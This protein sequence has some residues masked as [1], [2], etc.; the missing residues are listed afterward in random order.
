MTMRT[1][2]GDGEQLQF[3]KNIQ[4][5]LQDGSFVAS[6]KFALLHSLADLAVIH[7]DDTSAPLVLTTRQIAEQFIKL[8]WQQVRPFRGIILKQNPGKQASVVSRIVEAHRQAG[9]S[10]FRMSQNAKVW[11]ELVA[12]VAKTVQV[13][14]LWKLQTVGNQRVEF[15]Y[16][17]HDRGTT[18]SLKPGV[19]YCLRSFHPVLCSIFRSA[20][21]DYLRRANASQLG[22]DDDLQ[23]FLFGHERGSLDL[24]KPILWDVQRAQCFYCDGALKEAAEVDHFIPWSRCHSDLAHNFVLAHRNCN[25]AKSD[26]LA[27][28]R[29]LAAWVKRNTDRQVEL[30]QRFRAAEVIQDQAASSRI[31]AWAY[32]C[33]EQ[34]YSPVWVRKNEFKQLDTVWRRILI[35]RYKLN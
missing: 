25:N 10:F 31:A 2:P 23:E 8:Y 3:L 16:E 4:R 21:I 19:A 27:S 15:L 18:I 29:H 30:E 20:W 14:P 35:D 1:I 17:N 32:T 34:S 24:F 26:H 9:G 7:G 13:M 12:D 33:A 5:L 11:K 28:E 22:W 6:Y